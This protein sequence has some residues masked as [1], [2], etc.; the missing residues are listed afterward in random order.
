M[1]V[2]PA[3]AGAAERAE[4][5][6]RRLQPAEIVGE[7][8]PVHQHDV[9]ALGLLH[10]VVGEQRLLAG[11]AREQQVAALAETDVGLGAEAV[12]RSRKNATPNALMRMFS[13]VENCWRIEAADRVV[14]AC[15]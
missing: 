10:L 3:L 12:F 14:A 8:F 5:Q 9:G 11:L 2:E 15:A 4:P 1:G 13:G 7:R 6:I